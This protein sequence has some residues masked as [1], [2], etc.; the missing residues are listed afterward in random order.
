MGEWLA[1]SAAATATRQRAAAG[2]WRCS[3]RDAGGGREYSDAYPSP[4]RAASR[5]TRRT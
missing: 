1:G 3:S 2:P 5:G 4:A